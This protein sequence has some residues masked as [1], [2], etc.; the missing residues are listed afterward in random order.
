M[1]KR[2]Q[3]QTFK[4]YSAYYKNSI[5]GHGGVCIL[6]KNNFIHSQVQFQA[7]L[8]ALAVCITINKKT[9]TVASVYVPPSETLN[10]LAFDRMINS[11]SSRYLILGDFNG[12]SHLWGANQENERGKIVEKLIDR[13]NLILL[14]DSVHTRFDTYHQ[15]S[16]LL[17]LSLCHPSIYM[18]VACEISSDRLGSDHHPI[19]ITANTS[20]HPV[21]ERV[22]KWNFKKAKWDAFQDQCITEITPDFFND[23]EDKMAIFSSTLLDIAADNIPK[24][25]PFPKRKAKPWFDEDCQAAKKERNKANRLANKHPSAANSMRA[26]LIQAR[27]KMLFKQKKR[28]SW[29]NYVS[30]VNVNTPSKKVW[31]MIRK[32]TGKNVASPM[33]HLKDDN[34][35]LITDRVEIA[36]TLGAA[37]EKSSSSNNYSKE[38][39]SIK[40]QKEKQKINFKTNRNLRYNKKFTMRDLK[41]SLKKSNNSSP[42]PDQIHY[43]ILRHLP[44]ETL[45]I[46]LDIINETWKS[47]TFPESWRE[48]LIISIPK[49]GKDHFNPLNYRPIALTSCICKTVERMVNER[50]VWY[51]EKN[52]LLA[53]QQCGYRSNRSTVDHLVRLETF[54]RDAFIHNQHLVA[55]FFDLQKGYDTTWKYGIL[56][57][58]HNMGLRGNLPIFIG[59]FLSDR[60]FQIHLGTILSDKI[61]HQEE[62]VPQGAILSTTLFNVK[63][64]DIVKQVDPGVECSLYVDDFVIMYR[65]PTIDAIQRK[66]QHTIHRLE[67]W[68]LENGFTIS[69]NKTVAMHFCPDKK[70]MDPVLKLENDPI[71]FVKEAKFLGLIWDT[72]L[73]FEPH[74]KYLKARCQKSLNILKVLSRTEWGADQTT[75]LKLYRSLVRSKLDYGCLVYGSASKTALAKLDP[76]H[77]QGLRLSLGAFRSSPVESL[78]VEALE[79]PLEIR[80]EKLAL[81]YILKLKANPENPAYDVVKIDVEEI[82]INSVPDVPIWDSEPVTVDF[83]LSEFDKSSTSTVFKSR[84]NE[85]KQKY[86]DFCHIYTDG[87]K[88]E[89]KVASAYVCPYGTRGYRLRDGCSIFTAEVEAINKALTYVKVSTKQSFVIFSDSMS[90]LQAIESQESK[91]P[92]VNRVL[93][94][95]Q[96]ILSDGKFIT[97]CWLPSHR[98][99]RGN[100]DAD[101]AAKDALSKAQP[102]KFELPCTDVFMKIQPFISSLWQKRWDKE[103]AN[104]LHAIMPQIDDKYYSGCK[105]RKD[106]VII[107]RLRIGHTRLTHSF[108]ME[109]RPNPPLCDQCEGDHEL[110]VKHI[111]IECNFLKIIRRRHYDVTDLN[112]LFKTVS[113]KRILDFVKDI[114]L[115]NSL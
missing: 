67:K 74:I 112:Q 98:D 48:A 62:G 6:V 3:I 18:D 12:H 64:N 11:F 39:Q 108:R 2:D 28:D 105:N 10:E 34:G 78:Y 14:N 66:L 32:I 1:L 33:H 65:S 70:C 27:T 89:T 77:N 56:K 15:T 41:R 58:L 7:D 51:L 29:K 55:V 73:T 96:K 92:L 83:T 38:F 43:E 36:N 20:D 72:K 8:Q 107:N 53:K 84:F 101:R 82:A 57:D 23:A 86:L 102:E 30:S 75:L 69:K 95:C 99:I 115:Y 113:S 19:I 24:T 21:P 63:I 42:G 90:V 9:Y 88:V 22:P 104:K 52:G 45:H 49:P 17:D 80:R 109:N 35:T 4:H 31:D 79:P 85:V 59:N 110:T 25:S 106:E 47:D 100:E 91:N 46:L 50:L 76:V 13:H 111:L 37:I 114:G 5:N 94:A 93:E 103:V 97:F 54:I 61:F 60:T 16:S 68:T 26:R 44:I 81:Q 71:Q 40:A 87:S